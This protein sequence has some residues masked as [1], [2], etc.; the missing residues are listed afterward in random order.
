MPY[1]P[2]P[3]DVVDAV[4]ARSLSKCE[5][6]AATGCAGSP[7]PRRATELHHRQAK[8]MGGRKGAHTAENLLHLCR[9][10]HDLIHSNPRWSRDVGLIVPKSAPAPSTPWENPT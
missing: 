3:A 9:G 1:E 5:A 2:M 6:F 4:K 10:C 7:G 8:G